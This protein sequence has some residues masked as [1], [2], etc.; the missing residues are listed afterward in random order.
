MYNIPSRGCIVIYRASSPL[1][2][3][4]E[5]VTDCVLLNRSSRGG[6]RDSR[7]LGL[8][9]WASNPPVPFTQFMSLELTLLGPG[10]LINK[11]NSNNHHFTVLLRSFKLFLRYQPH[12]VESRK[13]ENI[14]F[15]HMYYWWE[16]SPHLTPKIFDSA[17]RSFLSENRGS[18]CSTDWLPIVRS[19]ALVSQG[20]GL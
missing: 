19:P 9:N 16:K 6:E 2:D 10:F 8:K 18:L 7:L 3:I 17:H 15:K 14:P 12:T 13:N 20:L 11:T 5:A 1:L 4:Y